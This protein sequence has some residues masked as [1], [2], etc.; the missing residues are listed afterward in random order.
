MD[1]NLPP[2]LYGLMPMELLAVV[3]LI[4]HKPLCVFPLYINIASIISSLLS[5]LQKNVGQ[6]GGIAG[7]DLNVESAWE[8]GYTGKGVTTAIMD[9][10]NIVCD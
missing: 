10:G 5:P 2:P 3:C 4:K 9:D 7:L 6:S 1:V 8:M